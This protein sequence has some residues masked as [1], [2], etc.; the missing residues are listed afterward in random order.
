MLLTAMANISRE[1][2]D[3]YS[4]LRSAQTKKLLT[5]GKAKIE[6]SYIGG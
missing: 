6:M 5:T 3:R 4:K 2:T 1:R